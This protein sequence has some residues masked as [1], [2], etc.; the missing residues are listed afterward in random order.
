MEAQ[1][2]NMRQKVASRFIIDADKRI[3]GIVE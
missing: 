3:D 1:K 2:L